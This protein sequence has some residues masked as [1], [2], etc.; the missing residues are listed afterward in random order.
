MIFKSEKEEETIK[1]GEKFASILKPGD[2]LGLDGELGSGKT[3]F[4][5]G[6]CRYFRVSEMVNSPTF[7]FVNEYSGEEPIG[8][9]RI[10]IYHFDLYRITCPAELDIIG[11]NEYIRNDSIVIIEWCEIAEIYFGKKLRKV[12]FE[13]GNSENMR[14]IKW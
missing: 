13:H 2:I 5:K 14:I 6:I 11:F 4:A 3:R 9:K 10:S 1:A 8:G 7:I 12:I